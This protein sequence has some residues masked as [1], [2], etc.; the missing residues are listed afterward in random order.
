[1]GKTIYERM[2]DL[3]PSIVAGHPYTTA[4]GGARLHIDVLEAM[5][6]AAPFHVDMLSL[7]DRAGQK[8]AEML[9]AEA[10]FITSGA[11][12]GLTLAAAAVMTGRD[13][14]LMEQLPDTENPVR[15]R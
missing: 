7:L 6:E 8:A 12:A 11:C 14:T 13:F 4:Q 9:G 2:F 15:I 1:M 3:K 5:R 10:A